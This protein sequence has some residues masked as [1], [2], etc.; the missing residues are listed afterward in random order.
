MNLLAASLAL[1]YGEKVHNELTEEALRPILGDATSLVGPVPPAPEGV[2][3]ATYAPPVLDPETQ[4]KTGV[5]ALVQR[6]DNYGRNT[7]DLAAAWTARYPS[8]GDFDTWALKELLLLN[9]DQDVYGIDKFDLDPSRLSTVSV[10]ARRPDDDF[11]N[12]ER[13]AH[14]PDRKPQA[15]VPDDP[16]IL[17]MGKLGAL[18]SQ[19]HAHYGLDQLEFSEDPAVLQTDPPRFAVAAGWP[20]GPV[21]T[22][23]AEMTQSHLDLS[24]LAALEGYGVLSNAYAGQA[25]HYLEDT[26]N[27]IHTV[28]VGLYDFFKDAFF[29]RLGKSIL[30]GG[31]YLGELPSLASIG[32]GILTNHHTISEQLA[33]KKLLAGDARLAGAITADDAEFLAKLPSSAAGDYGLDATRALIKASAPDGAPMYASTRAIVDKRYRKWGVSFDDKNDDP[34]ATLRKGVSSAEMDA[35]WGLQERSFKRAA[36]AVRRV[37][38]IHDGAIQGALATAEAT[39]ALR[40]S[41]LDR[42]V[43]RQLKLRA[44]ADE[45]RAKYLANPPVASSAPSTQPVVLAA[46]V[47]GATLVGFGL[48]RGFRRLRKS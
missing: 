29:Q 40:T 39:E 37:W 31:G 44:E 1:A 18:S 45:R 46:E 12:R 17:N 47:G 26:G 38:T 11:R 42:L 48:S 14:G 16:I 13:L 8:P 6:I 15:G 30:T 34:D 10:S 36:T 20:G 25:F 33:E 28:Q 9:P 32:I 22:L 24:T 4:A 43:R 27:P 7:P 3:P 23:A 2:D 35:F 41:T 19:A 5:A 21:V